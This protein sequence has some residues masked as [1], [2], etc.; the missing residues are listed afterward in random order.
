LII[1]L[2]DAVISSKETDRKLNLTVL[3]KG[4]EY[5]LEVPVSEEVGSLKQ[6]SQL[7]IGLGFEQWQPDFYPEIAAVTEHSPAYMAKLQSGDR[8]KRLNS[9]ELNSRSDFIQRIHELP[10]QSVELL[11]ERNGEEL[12]RTVQVAEKLINGQKQGIIGVSLGI[13]KEAIA[14]I[15]TMRTRLS[16]GPI[17]SFKKACASTYELSVLSLKM[18]REMLMGKVSLKNLNGPLSIAEQASYS[19][20][21]GLDRFIKFLALISIALG[22]VNLLPIP[23]LDGGQIVFNLVELVK[24]SPVSLRTEL[25]FQQLGVLCV[26]LIMGLAIFNDVERLFF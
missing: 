21:S 4:A 2:L 14:Q 11:I 17:T 8:I 15:Q 23:M 24:G 19:A 10:N 22:I 6:P 1:S 16:Y 18:F 7:L 5:V 26:F 25:I 12:Y 20:Q 3:R 9:F 13:P